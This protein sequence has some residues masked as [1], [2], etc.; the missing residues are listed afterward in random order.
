MLLLF[1]SIYYVHLF[2]FNMHI[3]NK[4]IEFFFF[5]LLYCCC[6][7]FALTIL[8]AYFFNNL[9]GYLY[10]K[11]NRQKKD[12]IILNTHTHTHKN[13]HDQKRNLQIISLVQD[14]RFFHFLFLFFFS[15]I[16]IH[17]CD[18]ISYMNRERDFELNNQKERLIE[19]K[20]AKF[21][22]VKIY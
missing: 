16:H 10:K 12:V 22:L 7:I 13:T 9:S 8:N 20:Y 15:I 17:P 19:S 5:F 1:V 21:V 14:R 2:G 4:H 18:A 11:N 3:Y 6:C